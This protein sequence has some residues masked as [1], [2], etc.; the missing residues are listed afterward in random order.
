MAIHD[1]AA[2]REFVDT[3]E[4]HLIRWASVHAPRDRVDDYVQE[5]WEHLFNR[6]W[7]NLLQWN[8]LYDDDEWHEHS[9]KGF[10]KTITVNKVTDLQRAAYLRRL[11]YLDPADILMVPGELG[12]DPQLQA[13]ATRLMAAY[14]GCTSHYQRKD[15]TLVQMWF[16]GHSANRIAEELETNANNIHQRKSYLFKRLQDCL[17]EK[18]PEYFHD[19]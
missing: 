6:D 5:V 17:T 10:L 15:H 18:L 1:Q 3:W 2:E 7:R 19:V 11:K 16:E 13:E 8:A 9:L 14:E 12:N 4:P